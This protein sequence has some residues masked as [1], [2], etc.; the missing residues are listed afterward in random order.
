MRK[1]F[2]LLLFVMLPVLVSA[3]PKQH[4]QSIP[5][6]FTHVTVIDATGAPAKPDMTV[7]IT[8]EH[9]TAI[10]KTGDVRMPKDAMVVNATGK[11][12]IPGLWDMHVHIFNQVSQRPP[13]AWYFP[14]FVANG[15][16]GARE[17][18]TRPQDMN[19]ILEWRRQFAEGA[20]T[21][22]R[23]VAVGTV[24][25]G[26]PSIW[27]NTDT[28]ATPEEARRMVRKIKDA[29]VDFVKTYSNLS[30]EAYFAIV[31]ETR[32][33]NI[34][35]AGHVPFAVGADEASN[36]VQRTMEHLNQLLETCS[37]KEQ[38]LLQVP[39]KDWSIVY[40]KLMVDT[41]D[42][43]KCR[44]LFSLL[45]ENHTWQVPTL[46]RN[47][48][49]YF[50]GDLRY[51]NESPRLK[52]I[53][54]DEQDKWKPYI[55]RQKSLSENE[56][57]LRKEVWRAY[58]ALVRAMRN[59]GVEFMAGTDV[60]NEYIYPGFSLHDE[61]V[62]L[63]KAGLTPMDALQTATVNPA[64]FLGREKDLGTVQE[65]KIADLVL[66]GANP[67]KDI[68]NTQKINAVVINGRLLDRR[69]LDGLLAQAEAAVKKK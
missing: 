47:E 51:F 5:L 40:D 32:K 17:M 22:P 69:V 11:F 65:G 36:A 7:V 43:S 46:I 67:L 55:A 16:I 62:L 18:W 15:V 1:A 13:N 59:A 28:V 21:L 29:G 25:D 56:K 66:L 64:R 6:V 44:K 37:S 26:Q 60:G 38:E 41:Y 10:G 2:P 53:P 4:P 48:M 12:L 63:V 9:I 27:P 3:Q 31:D 8:G 39:G 54:V 45:A 42:E 35:F 24:I 58:L 68:S 33:Q 50:S 19:Q 34:P 49:H 52:Y 57:N 30:R 23:I 61:L 20:F 14:L